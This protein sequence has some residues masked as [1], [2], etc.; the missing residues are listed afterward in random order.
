MGEFRQVVG[1]K[2]QKAKPSSLMIGPIVALV[3]VFVVLLFR[4]IA[5]APGCDNR[6]EHR[7]DPQRSMDERVDESPESDRMGHR[8]STLFISIPIR[9]EPSKQ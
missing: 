4:I 9:E 2:A 5:P 8:S 1:G 3:E 7:K 6:L